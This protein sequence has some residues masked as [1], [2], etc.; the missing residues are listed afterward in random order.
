MTAAIPKA[1]LH[2]HLEGAAPPALVRRKS[3][4]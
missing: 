4:V 1:E 3:V 2:C